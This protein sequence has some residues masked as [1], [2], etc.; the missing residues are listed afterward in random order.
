LIRALKFFG[1]ACLVGATIYL[2][3][4]VIYA[5]GSALNEG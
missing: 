1:E 5:V 3:T 2:L 4:L